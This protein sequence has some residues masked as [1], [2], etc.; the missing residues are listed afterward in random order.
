[1]KAD[2]YTALLN[3]IGGASTKNGSISGIGGMLSD[4]WNWLK[5]II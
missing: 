3:N 5:S 4:G 2:L 1:L